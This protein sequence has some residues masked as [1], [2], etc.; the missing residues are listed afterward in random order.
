MMYARHVLGQKQYEITDHLGDVL[1]TISDKRAN[2]SLTGGSGSVDTITS[3][4]PIV[5]TATD[6][7]PFGMQMPGRYKAD[8]GTHCFTTTVT[9]PVDYF[10]Y[11]YYPFNGYLFSSL[12]TFGSAYLTSSI[13]DLILNTSGL[14][15]DSLSISIDSLTPGVA[16]TIKLYTHGSVSS[17]FA[18]IISDGVVVGGWFL[19]TTPDSI[20]MSFVP[21]SSV[22]TLNIKQTLSIFGGGGAHSHLNLT[23]MSVPRFDSVTLED[24]VTTVCTEDR[25]QYGY[26]GKYKDNEWAGLG[27]DYSY[28]VRNYLP[29]I[30][31]FISVD[32]LAIKYPWYT[33]Y[34]FS[35]NSPIQA[36]DL[37][38]REEY[39]YTMT[40]GSQGQ[41][42]LRID[43]V[44]TV[45]HHSW[46]GGLIEF[47]TKIDTKRYIVDYNGN[48]YHIG[49]PQVGTGYGNAW[50]VE[51][52]ENKYL[53]QQGDAVEFENS[54]VD[55]KHSQAASDANTVATAQLK[56]GDLVIPAVGAEELEVHP[57]AA[58]KG[59]VVPL[60]ENGA[61]NFSGY[62]VKVASGQKNVLKNFF[63]TGSYTKDFAKAD[64][65]A[66]FTE[67][68]PRPANT[69]W[70]HVED[71]N[72][73]TNTGTLQLVQRNVHQATNP[74]KGG[75]AQYRAANNGT[76]Y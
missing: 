34:Q 33:P 10:R 5:I 49:F 65:L 41:A 48:R 26:N 7:Y 47:D 50:S 53:R 30:G 73:N 69:T 37:D 20:S 25:Y 74:H 8:T 67:K 46:L 72:S 55:D 66:G 24:L 1:A 19:S 68:N 76:G 31:R 38:G 70:H 58:K 16:Q 32:P 35:G 27:C 61:P 11:T 29:R 52:F 54:Y 43:N 44:K 21:S 14:P 60:K 45:N 9:E 59:Y 39:H 71:Y 15:D 2:D 12:T 40:M 17:Y 22:V 28:G 63:Y 56:A 51:S 6:Y 23:G 57:N 13:T 42:Q 18:E 4:K 36:V 62:I 75:A 64:I 3:W